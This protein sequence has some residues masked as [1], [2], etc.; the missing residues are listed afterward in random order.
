[1]F[2]NGDKLNMIDFSFFYNVDKNV[3]LKNTTI[4]I[5]AK[6]DNAKKV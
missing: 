3:F 2:L 6:I 5:D 4:K 1:M